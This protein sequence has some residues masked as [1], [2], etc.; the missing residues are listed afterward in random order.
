MKGTKEALLRWEKL[1][2][3]IRLQLLNNFYC[4]SCQ[5]I[6]SAADTSVSLVSQDLLIKGS[7]IKCG[8]DIA[9]HIEND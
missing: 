9:R 8:S 6:T 2:G 3:S 4:G 5:S 7:C 1:P